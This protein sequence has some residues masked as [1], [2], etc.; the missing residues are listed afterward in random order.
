[1]DAIISASGHGSF[2]VLESSTVAL[3][4]ELAWSSRSLPRAASDQMVTLEHSA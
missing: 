2:G 3:G 1:M 4:L